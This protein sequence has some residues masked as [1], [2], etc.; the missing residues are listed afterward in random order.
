MDRVNFLKEFYSN[1]E[2]LNLC[3][4]TEYI[5]GPSKAWNLPVIYMKEKDSGSVK[6]RRSGNGAKI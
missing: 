5:Y 6:L 1:R 2:P 3:T 4:G